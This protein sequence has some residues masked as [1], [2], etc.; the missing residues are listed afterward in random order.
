MKKSILTLAVSTALIAA[1]ATLNVFGADLNA[2]N[3]YELENVLLQQMNKYNQD[4]EIRYTGSW[5]NIEDVLKKSISKDTYLNS[6]IKSIG[7]VIEGTAKSST[8]DVEVEYIITSVERAA[9]DKQIKNIIT[10]IIKPYM[11]DHEKVKAVHDYIV[12]NGK[13]DKDMMLYSDYDLL[14][15]GSSVCNG[16]ALLTYNMLEE[17]N[18]PVK[19]VTG[20]GNGELHIWN[21]VKLG[22]YWF[23]LDTT[24]DDPLPDKDMVSYNYYMLTDKE[25]LRDHTI[26]ENQDLPK[27]AKS[28]YDYLKELSYNKILMETGLDVYDDINTAETKEELIKILEYKIKHHP[29]KISVRINKDI[30]QEIFNNSISSLLNKYNYISL[31]SYG[32]L[33][34]DNT[35][36]YYILNL[37]VKYNETPD[38]IEFDFSDKVYNTATKVNFNVYAMFGNKKINITNDV[39]IYPYNIEGINIYDGTLTFKKAGSYNIQFEYQGIQET[40]IINALN[41]EAF[42]YITDKKPDKDVNVKVYDQYIDFSSINQWPFIEDG[43][44]MV[45]L[46]AVFEVMNCNVRWDAGKSSAVVQYEN[47]SIIIPTNSKTAYINGSAYSL[48]VPARLVNDRIMV[49]L[50]FIS[51]SIDKTVIWDDANKTV[52]IY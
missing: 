11:N 19:L 2:S 35:G 49:P 48:D 36:E 13:Y 21:M 38:S 6:N 30:S 40:V 20:T 22:D 3:Y 42:E 15:Q 9:A 50:R 34:N 31:I 41:S 46:R 26:D 7:W 24:W 5:D 43:R 16:Y 44:T 39:L 32:N 8:I 25:I 33:N 37:Y 47:T 23:H 14:T 51:E 28:Y 29:L 12:I 52:L 18:I 1:S 17:L 27:A 4:F 45:P 10:E